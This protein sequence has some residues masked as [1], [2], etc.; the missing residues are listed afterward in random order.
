MQNS[1]FKVGDAFDIYLIKDKCGY[2]KHVFT[3]GT[4]RPGEYK[5]FGLTPLVFSNIT[6]CYAVNPRCIIKVA[7]MIITKLK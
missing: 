7:R 5:G 1:D 3:P 2:T 6:G 4:F